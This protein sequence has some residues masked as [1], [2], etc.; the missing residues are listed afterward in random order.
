MAGMSWPT[1]F[2]QKAGFGAEVS[3]EFVAVSGV[4]VGRSSCVDI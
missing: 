3:C 2:R 4:A 1:S